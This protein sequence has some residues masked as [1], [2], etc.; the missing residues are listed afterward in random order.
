MA[1]EGQQNRWPARA[2]PEDGVGGSQG[3]VRGRRGGAW[4]LGGCGSTE[5]GIL[6]Q[7]RAKPTK[8]R[9]KLI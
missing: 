7:V 1:G 6:V 5:S 8:G 2:A 3:Q 4:G 9:T